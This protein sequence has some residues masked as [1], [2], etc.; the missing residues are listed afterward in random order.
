M[1]QSDIQYVLELLNDAIT[2]KDWEKVEEAI[3]VLK[4]FKDG[5]DFGIDDD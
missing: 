5:D 3:E 4:E 1:D 2:C